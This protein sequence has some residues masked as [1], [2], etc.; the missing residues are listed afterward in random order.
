MHHLQGF[1]NHK[2]TRA[3]IDF[4]IRRLKDIGPE[5]LVKTL[6]SPPQWFIKQY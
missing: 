3:I 2:P 1:G 6:E 5:D 4:I